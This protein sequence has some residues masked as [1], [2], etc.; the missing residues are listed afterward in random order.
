MAN[1]AS[2]GTDSG[3]ISFVKMVKCDAPSMK[4]DSRMSRGSSLM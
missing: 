1:D 3:R 4:A 2:A